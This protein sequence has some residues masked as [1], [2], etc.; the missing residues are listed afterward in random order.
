MLSFQ[1]LPFLAGTRR[2]SENGDSLNRLSR[3]STG[4][5]AIATVNI[6]FWMFS[7]IDANNISY[8]D[9]N[10]V[11]LRLM[12]HSPLRTNTPKECRG[13]WNFCEIL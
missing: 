10:A 6:L 1:V 4:R 12:H 3:K 9:V 2:D 7:R 5:S 13:F 11:P 8:V